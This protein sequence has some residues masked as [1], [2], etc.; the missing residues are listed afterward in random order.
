MRSR[1]SSVLVVA[2]VAG[3]LVPLVGC[4]E[5]DGDGEGDGSRT[6]IESDRTVQ[7]G[8]SAS[9]GSAP[10]GGG[11][12]TVQGGSGAGR[13]TGGAAACES[14]SAQVLAEELPD[15]DA[16]LAGIP[17]SGDVGALVDAALAR[18]YP[19]GLELVRGGRMET[20]F[21]DCSVV[22]AG[23]PRSA[24]EVY[25]SMEIIVHECGHMY[26]AFLSSANSDAYELSPELS[27]RCERGDTQSRGGDTFARSR[28]AGDEYSALRP[29]CG[30]VSRAGCD[31]YADVYLN[32]DPDD[33]LFE[34]G[35]QG[36]NLLLEEA[37]QY[38][39][40]IATAWAFADQQPTNISVSARD[41]ILT[42][43]WYIERYL[44]MARTEFPGAYQ[45]ITADDCWRDLTLGIWARAQRYL[46]LSRNER[47]LGIADDELLDL[48]EEPELLEE[49]ERLRALHECP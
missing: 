21:G 18:R 22:F 36:F 23:D 48:V 44:R 43:L 31:P 17:F 13:G 40:S 1:R 39:N 20:T 37:V 26:D 33:A 46:A 35:D 24:G 5:G 47:G 30:G 16:S 15:P 49:I 10:G 6:A 3:S 4:G 38:V 45:R 19:F 9:G 28:I 12:S 25:E 27:F 41:G 7:G 29:A 8:S 32:G 11:L 2:L 14:L 34:S 42:F